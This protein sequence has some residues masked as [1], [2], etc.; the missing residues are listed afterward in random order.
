MCELNML[1]K[2]LE[3]CPHV[4]R[5][6]VCAG[7]TVSFLGWRAC[8]L[9]E[10]WAAER[11]C[12]LHFKPCKTGAENR[13][14]SRFENALHNA[15]FGNCLVFLW[16]FLCTFF[17]FFCHTRFVLASNGYTNT[18]RSSDY[19]WSWAWVVTR[20]DLLNGT[21]HETRIWSNSNHARAETNWW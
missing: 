13:N 9:C 5:S 11:H 12:A 14:S 2:M 10:N 19:L 1:R 17:F 16:Q 8:E 4:M 15:S 7:N 3:E 21:L 20:V 18:S 6:S